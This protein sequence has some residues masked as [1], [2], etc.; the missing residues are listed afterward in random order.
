ML[1]VILYLRIKGMAGLQREDPVQ[2]HGDPGLVKFGFGDRMGDQE[3]LDLAQFDLRDARNQ[4]PPNPGGK[5][6]AGNGRDL[7]EYF[8]KLLIV[9]VRLRA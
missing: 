6:E 4:L 3:M 1:T 5:P 7:I 2:S 8:R 9:P